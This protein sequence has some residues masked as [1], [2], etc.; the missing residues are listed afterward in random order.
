MNW[1]ES[2]G[3]SRRGYLGF[4]DPNTFNINV[5]ESAGT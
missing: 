2:D 3:T 4:T 5:Q 1:Y